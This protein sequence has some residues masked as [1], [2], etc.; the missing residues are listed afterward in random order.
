MHNQKIK[1]MQ[2][3]LATSRQYQKTGLN[4]F[5]SWLKKTVNKIAVALEKVG[6]P[7]ASILYDF[8]DGDG[9]FYGIKFG[10]FWSD[11]EKQTEIGTNAKV[12][13]AIT[14]DL[15]LTA[16]EETYLD[17]WVE[18]S[19]L[20]FTE[21][22]VNK[23]KMLAYS[24]PTLINFGTVYNEITMISAFVEWYAL[25]YQN[26]ITNLTPVNV[27]KTQIA[28]L[29]INAA[30]I[31][32]QLDNYVANAGVSLTT[33]TVSSKV[34]T[35]LNF[36]GLGINIP[37]PIQL[38]HKKLTAVNLTLVEAPIE[39]VG[40]EPPVAIDEPTTTTPGTTNEDG[41]SIATKSVLLF[42]AGFILNKLFS[43]NN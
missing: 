26:Y 13:S 7:Y 28:L 25:N 37:G 10:N 22:Y 27:V 14:V 20:P 35:S 6:F 30:V 43:N 21:S 15:P 9:K 23:V 3:K 19:V 38:T 16:A 8:T 5:F 4:G 17:H 39:T 32:E 29:Q 18:N 11:Q 41:S 36:K 1:K 2:N 24:S 33:E 40:N 12:L 42:T 34:S 31:Q